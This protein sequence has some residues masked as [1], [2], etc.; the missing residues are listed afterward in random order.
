MGG[1]FMKKM[2][3]A[4]M[5]AAI[6]VLTSHLIY[7][8]VGVAKCFPMQ[9]AVNVIA[10]VFLGPWYAVATAFVISLMRNIMGVGSILA[11]PGSMIG[12]FIAGVAYMK[13]RKIEAA[14]IGEVIGTGFIGGMAA[15]P[16]A[17]VF[18]G[19]SK[20]AFALII[21]FVVSSMGGAV[22]SYVLLKTS[23]MDKLKDRYEAH[24]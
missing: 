8:P 2:V 18:L 5:L 6:G 21:P 11:F 22:I 9:H 24:N 12:A 7:I 17:N 4:A 19:T 10:A 1:F 14:V 3:L 15:V 23:A 20:A 13:I 16:M